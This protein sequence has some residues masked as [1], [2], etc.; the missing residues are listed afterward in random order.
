MRFRFLILITFTLLQTGWAQLAEMKIIGNPEKSETDIV[1]Q[2]DANGRF[3]AAIQVISDMEGFQY[4]A[5]NGVVRMEDKPGSDIV[6]LQPDER[7]LEIYH[8]GY[9]KLQIIL[10][11]VGI[12][13]QPREL[14][15]IKIEGE[16]K[17]YSGKGF[18]EI[19]TEPAGAD[20]NI[21]GIPEFTKKSPYV[22]KKLNAQTWKFIISKENYK[23]EELLISVKKD[24]S[25]SKTIKLTPTFGYISVTPSVPGADLYINGMKRIY[26]SGEPVSVP[27]GDVR[28]QLKKKYYQDFEQVLSIEPN[29]KRANSIP[30]EAKM[31]RELGEIDVECSVSGVQVYLDGYLMGTAPFIKEVQAGKHSVQCK[32]SGY[33]T[34]SAIVEI[35]GGER[36]KK[37]FNITQNALVAIRGTNGASVY[38]DGR[39]MG[40]IPLSGLEVEPGDHKIS[41]QKEAYD[42]VY[43]SFSV[44]SERRTLS[45]NLTL[46]RGKFFRFSAF[47]NERISKISNGV[48]L[49]AG[50]NFWDFPSHMVRDLVTVEND[51][52]LNSISDVSICGDISWIKTPFNIGASLRGSTTNLSMTETE[53]DSINANHYF[54]YIAII[55]FVIKESL[56]PSVGLFYGKGKFKYK[57]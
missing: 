3:C 22:Y 2:R 37:Y 49:S 16:A 4:E 45:Y 52:S 23:P 51:L 11:D 10:N 41:V 27:V 39:L 56:Y 43:S 42:P 26:R 24:R 53:K 55:P 1:A 50:V 7:V 9:A 47:G 21:D 13:L 57:I 32:K 40:T 15:T 48:T 19:I 25:L 35:L 28:V 20:I 34:E 18:L 17:Y 33:R 6:Y 30:L 8:S 54:G 36:L 44:E 14:W 5:Y 31:I 46:T 12:S 38:I 29:D